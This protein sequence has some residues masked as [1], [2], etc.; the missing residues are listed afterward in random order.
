MY[1]IAELK[2]GIAV[3]LDGQPYLV[4]KAQHSKQAR[5][6]GVTKTT[7]KNLITGNVIPKTFQGSER[8][9]PAEITYSKAQFLYS[10][11]D[12]AHFMDS[13]SYEQFSLDKDTV[14]EQISYMVEGTE[15]D[16]RNFDGKPIAVRIAPKVT[17]EVKDTPPG[18]KGDTATGGTKPATLETG[19][20]VQVP[21]FVNPGDKIRV[22]T[23]T[24]T[25]VERA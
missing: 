25:Y 12:G 17:L 18:V 23:E 16:I 20:I 6:A 11:S 3:T 14:E 9:E 4:T 10:N 22:N 15:V 19:L 1:S 2:P 13:A 24:G 7:V 8:I 21:L 5:G